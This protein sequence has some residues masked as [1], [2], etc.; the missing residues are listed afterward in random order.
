MEMKRNRCITHT[1]TH[2]RTNISEQVCVHD[3]LAIFMLMATAAAVVAKA[4][5][6]DNII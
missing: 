5:Q 4:I 3:I 1:H 6:T 2:T